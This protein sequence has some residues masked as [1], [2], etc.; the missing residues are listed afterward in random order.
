MKKK[1]IYLTLITA[2][3]TSCTNSNKIDNN[4]ETQN[5]LMP[6]KIIREQV[7]QTKVESRAKK[8]KAMDKFINSKTLEHGNVSFF[9]V[10]LQNGKVVDN[11]RGE[12][13]L[14]P[15]SVLKV[16]TSATALEV[17]GPNTVLETK[18]LYD[19]KISK[20]GVL[21]GNIYIQGGGDPTLGSDG[22]SIDREEFLK[23]WMIEVKRAGIKSINGNI[24][25][26]DDLFGYEGI[27]GKWLWEDLGTNYGQG[28]YGISVFDN[29][30][31]LY[32]N[33]DISGSKPKIIKTKPEIAGLTFDNQG[34]VTSGGK[35]NLYVRGV[36]LENKR[37]IYGV[38]PQNKNGLT[39]QSDIPDPGL[40]LGQYFSYYLKRENIKFNGNITT[41][42]LNSQRPKNPKIIAVTQ[43]PPISEIV[44]ILLT[45]SDNHYTEHLY[46]LIEKTK[47]I[48]IQKYWEDKGV[49]IHSLTLRDGSGLSRGNTV[50]AKLLVDILIES[51]SNLENLLPVAG[52]DGTVA[53]FLKNSP[54]EGNVKVKSGSMSGIQSYAGY[55]NKNGKKYAFAIIINHW[56][57]DRKELR[58]KIETLLNDIF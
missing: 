53:L 15:A 40:F 56:N 43:S 45:R 57:G 10:D 1:Y 11:Y 6:E 52:K 30:Y 50:S 26:L 19:G 35:K 14:V 12:T 23:K 51:Q 47:G 28:T 5:T 22:I 21:N 2:F 39:I 54:L 36:P 58:N 37:R 18:V 33:T 41:A 17:L 31:T 48:S 16:V 7:L 9:A 13:A 20:D 38:V 34:L 55:V 24:I 3:L 32:L 4:I 8:S 29:I 49:D 42:R 44:K 46:Q 27:P 25:V